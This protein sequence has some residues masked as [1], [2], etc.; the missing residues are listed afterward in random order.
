MPTGE[1]NIN[2]SLVLVGSKSLRITASASSFSIL[3]TQS[4]GDLSAYTGVASGAPSEG[5]VGLWIY[6]RSGDLT[7]ITCRIGSSDADYT[8]ASGIKTYTDAFDVQDGWNYFVFK[9]TGGST[10]GTPVWSA[11]DYLR[12]SFTSSIADMIVVVDYCTIGD[13]NEIAANGLGER[14]TIYTTTTTVY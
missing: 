12:F 7:A 11:V 1:Y 2:D 14:F 6:A 10:T 9:L 5:V 13:G 8:E 4:F 3:T